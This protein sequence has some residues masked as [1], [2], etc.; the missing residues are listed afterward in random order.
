MAE[1]F[2]CECQFQLDFSA[3]VLIVRHEM[4]E[5]TFLYTQELKVI[6]VKIIAIVCY[7]ISFEILEI[8]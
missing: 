5:D 4:T 3:V 6:S 8:F 7:M 2:H 1:T